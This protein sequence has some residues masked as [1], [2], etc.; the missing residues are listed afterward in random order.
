MSSLRRRIPIP[1]LC[2]ITL[3]ACGQ[4]SAETDSVPARDA[5]TSPPSAGAQDLVTTHRYALHIKLDTTLVSTFT[6]LKSS[7]RRALDRLINRPFAEWKV[8]VMGQR[9]LI[10]LP[11]SHPAGAL[12]LLLTDDSVEMVVTRPGQKTRYAL[13]ADL[14][15]DVLD[16][17][18]PSARTDFDMSI[19][20]AT[21]GQRF[22]GP[23]DRNLKMRA[24][25][26]QLRL[27]YYSE[28]DRPRS[29]PVR[30]TLH[31]S[32]PDDPPLYPFHQPLLHA[33]LPLL[34]TRRGLLVLE[35]L[36]FFTGS[37]HWWS[38]TVVNEGKP[39][40]A[41][42]TFIA[43]LRDQGYRR[44]PFGE[45]SDLG[46][47][48]RRKSRLPRPD[49]SGMQLVRASDLSA[50]RSTKHRGPL[51]IRNHSGFAAYIFV[52]GVPLGWVS[53]GHNHSF[54]GV[55]AGYWR[56]YGVSPS[57]VRSWGPHDTYVPG[58]LTLR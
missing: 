51:K 52:D 15:P 36:A 54:S 37:P 5:M 49:R 13:A 24:F 11:E 6:N 17:R 23:L 53:P 56:I 55:P 27:R 10:A 42:P 19:Q 30:L 33:A 43:W 1:L 46:S 12:H 4:T 47:E 9:L 39:S 25:S 2:A 35:S 31:L 50:L 7:Q 45:I 38:L 14:L 18:G 41:P 34:Q 57:G 28:P 8:H 3:G 58:A 20:D 16:V 26:S 21:D 32:V 44:I 29:W 48:I 22:P 40:V